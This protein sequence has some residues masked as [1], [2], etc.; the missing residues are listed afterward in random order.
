MAPDVTPAHPMTSEDLRRF[1]ARLYGDHGWQT[2]LSRELLVND[3]TVRRW[4]A[5]RSPVPQTVAHCIRLMVFLDEL[6]W[7]GEWR[8]I[9]EEEY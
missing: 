7:L 4:V 2:A 5:G 9:V 6:S 1:G 8:K 3:R